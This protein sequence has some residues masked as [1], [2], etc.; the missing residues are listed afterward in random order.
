MEKNTINIIS[1]NC[2]KIIT[3]VN[4]EDITTLVP[5]DK[6]ICITDENIYKL[7]KTRFPTDKVIVLPSGE[8][9]K[10]METIEKVINKLI[11]YKVDKTNHLIA[12]G[13]GVISDIS[14]FVASIYM[15][16]IPFSFVPTTLLSQV[17]ASIGGK[18]G[19]NYNGIKNLIGNI[20]QPNFILYDL[21][22]ISTLPK[23]EFV[24]ALAEIVKY[25]LIADKNLIDYIEQNVENI[26]TYDKQVLQK[27]INWSISIKSQIIEKDPYEKDIRKYLNFGHTFGH[28]IESKIGIRHGEAVSLGMIISIE[29]SCLLN[30]FPQNERE[31]IIKLLQKLNL[32]IT[33]NKTIQN[34]VDLIEFDKK[35]E[36]ESIKLILLKS[37]GNP[38]IETLN[39]NFLKEKGNIISTDLI[40]NIEII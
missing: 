5:K 6:I 30:N 15:R 35:R 37:I 21:S 23:E 22:F 25:G 12:I 4:F 19:V 2:T 7:Y 40:K 8:A 27:L 36:G 13:G 18:N 33:L 28:V 17:D 24:S 9:Y 11:D 14:G 26:K 16:G 32:P 31:R 29:I 3:D 20:Q 10:N 34:Y 38:V 1:Q 39:I